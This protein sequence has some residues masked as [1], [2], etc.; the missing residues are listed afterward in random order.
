MVVHF[1]DARFI[2]PSYLFGVS[3]LAIA[4]VLDTRTGRRSI[5]GEG[6]APGQTQAI[7]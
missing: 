3:L 5:R 2:P 4:L 1:T 7:S 6:A